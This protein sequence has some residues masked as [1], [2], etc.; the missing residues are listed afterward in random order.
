[1]GW[2][3]AHPCRWVLCCISPGSEW[4]L[5]G[6]AFSRKTRPV[7]LNSRT[8]EQTPQSLQELCERFVTWAESR[9][10]IR[11]KVETE[12]VQIELE[13]ATSLGLVVN[14]LIANCYEH[15]FPDR[16]LGR[17]RCGLADANR[18]DFDHGTARRSSQPGRDG[19]RGRHSG[20]LHP[21]VGESEAGGSELQCRSARGRR[22]SDR[23]WR[24][25]LRKRG[26]V[27]FVHRPMDWS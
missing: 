17:G 3:A 16:A 14:E 21:A 9:P 19:Q 10:D 4:P 5:R 11:F 8:M 15:A 20:Q 7:S 18:R 25:G 26:R 1:M 23:S 13:H 22:R 6:A 12:P 24:R 27:V 2:A